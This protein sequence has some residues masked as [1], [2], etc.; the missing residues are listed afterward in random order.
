MISTLSMVM[1]HCEI[2]II[3]DPT[4]KLDIFDHATI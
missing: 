4:R 3:D 1:R 2:S